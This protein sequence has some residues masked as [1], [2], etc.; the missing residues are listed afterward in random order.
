MEFKEVIKARYR[1][2]ESRRIDCEIVMEY[3]DIVDENG[4]PTGETVSRDVAHRDGIR[5]HREHRF[6]WLKGSM[7]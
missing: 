4:Q 1:H 2:E 6:L 5:P 7:E 3:L